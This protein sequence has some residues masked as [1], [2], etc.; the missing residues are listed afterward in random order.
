[1]DRNGLIFD[2]FINMRKKEN[3]WELLKRLDEEAGQFNVYL[4][5]ANRYFDTAA[6]ET[7]NLLTHQEK[8]LRSTI[9]KVQRALKRFG[10]SKNSKTK[11]EKEN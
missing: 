4:S 7:K 11:S 8:K 5:E 1:L 10:T 3:L 2:N 6:K 9:N